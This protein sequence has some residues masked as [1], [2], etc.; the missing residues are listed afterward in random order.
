[1]RNRINF[2]VFHLVT[3]YLLHYA[4]FQKNCT[5]ALKTHRSCDFSWSSSADAAR[6]ISH[7]NALRPKNYH[8]FEHARVEDDRWRP[9]VADR[10]LTRRN[11]APTCTVPPNIFR[12]TWERSTSQA[13]R[14][15]KS[16]N[17]KN[18]RKYKVFKI[19]TKVEEHCCRL[20]LR[21]T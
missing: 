8:S 11:F 13:N 18:Y 21:S 6:M 12:A 9:I 20:R 2:T 3:A 19:T 4:L 5:D 7:E 17:G 14:R 10:H 16:P 15:R 1:M